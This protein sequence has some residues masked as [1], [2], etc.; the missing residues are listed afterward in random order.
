MA[1]LTT[2]AV[3][4][5]GC[6]VARCSP[7][8][9]LQCNKGSTPRE[10]ARGPARGLPFLGKTSFKIHQHRHRSVPVVVSDELSVLG[11]FLGGSVIR[12][13]LPVGELWV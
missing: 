7:F 13:C 9:Y 3:I 5:S 10:G 6:R 4:S 1:V 12:I 2:L 11:G 8:C